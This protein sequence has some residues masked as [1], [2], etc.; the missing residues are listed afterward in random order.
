[1]NWRSTIRGQHLIPEQFPHGVNRKFKTLH[2]A[3]SLEDIGIT[4]VQSHRWQREA[5]VPEDVFEKHIRDIQNAGAE[6]KLRAERKGGV[7]LAEMDRHKK[8][9]GRP[10]KNPP[11][12]GV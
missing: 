10:K 1:M 7:M 8:A 2:D 6:L 11:R 5:S 4:Y 9:D 12:W 3:R